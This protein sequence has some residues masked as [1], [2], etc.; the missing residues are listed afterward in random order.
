MVPTVGMLPSWGQRRAVGTWLCMPGIF[1]CKCSNTQTGALFFSTETCR[2]KS[3]KKPALQA[4]KQRHGT[5]DLGCSPHPSTKIIEHRAWSLEIHPAWSWV[6]LWVSPSA[7]QHHLIQHRGMLRWADG[8]TTSLMVSQ[9]TGPCPGHGWRMSWRGE[10]G[11]GLGRGVCS[12]TP[13]HGAGS[14]TR[15][16]RDQ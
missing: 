4:G 1:G 16:R 5:S 8:V 11:G 9:S 12:L 7:A 2:N 15:C 10:G 13:G 6:S 3:G 14:V